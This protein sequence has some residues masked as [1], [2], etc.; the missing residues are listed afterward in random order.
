MTADPGSTDLTQ[1]SRYEGG[2][3]RH[4]VHVAN[5]FDVPGGVSV[6]WHLRWVSALPDLD[7][8][9]YATSDV[10][11]AWRLAEGLELEGVARNL[12]DA[13]HGEWTGENGGANV[14]IQRDV[15]VGFVWRR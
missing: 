9:A 13:H 5:A 12:H 14:E 15:Y 6:D 8:D 10:R 4:Q 11:V 3:P 7:I 2:T 1:E